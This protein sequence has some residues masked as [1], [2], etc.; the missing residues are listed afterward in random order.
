MNKNDPN[1]LSHEY[2]KNLVAYLDA[3]RILKNLIKLQKQEED[4]QYIKYR[5]LSNDKISSEDAKR[6]A[7]ID[8]K[9][10]EQDQIIEQT[11]EIVDKHYALMQGLIWTKDL[12]MDA[13]ATKRKEM[14][15]VKIET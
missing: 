5:F 1:Y 8:I 9:V 13:N 6:K 15:F 4:K 3:K 14:E 12:T 7:S 10:T 2:Y 11:E